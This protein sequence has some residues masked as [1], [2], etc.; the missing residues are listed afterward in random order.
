[1]RG[2]VPLARKNLLADPRRLVV[3]ILGVGLAV[4]LMLLV[5]GLWQGTLSRITEYEDNVRAQL[6]V[7]ERG[8]RTFVSDASAVPAVTV[9]QVRRAP[10]VD[11]ASP[12]AARQLIVDQQGMKIPVML[13]GAEIDG[14]GGPWELTEGRAPENDDEVVIDD[15]FAGAYGYAVGDAI[16]LLGEHLRVVGLTPDSRAFGTGGMV[17]VSLATA[18]RLL[19]SGSPSFVLVRTEDPDGVATAI[20]SRTGLEVLTADRMAQGDRALYDDTLGSVIRLMLAIAFAAGTLIVALSVYSS[21]VDRLREYGIVKA[22]GASRRRLFRVVVS[23]TGSLAVLGAA[24]GL[25]LF[26]A[27]KAALAL[28]L[29]EYHVELPGSAIVASA[30]AVGA[31]ALLAALLPARRIGRLDPASVYGGEQP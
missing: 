2:D 18:A 19:G 22:L 27:A 8:T 25:A 13:V 23:Q 6:F 17:F 14:L 30:G 16:E 3:S 7:A 5:E 10:G 20:R 9:E 26:V 31:M 12:I 29:T 1:M 11:A 15:G 24:L 28:W 4:A 21:V